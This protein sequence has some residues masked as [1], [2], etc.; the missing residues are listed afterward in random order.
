MGQVR[1]GGGGGGGG[2]SRKRL[3]TRGV[4]RRQR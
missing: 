3:G 1:V 4:G 2:G